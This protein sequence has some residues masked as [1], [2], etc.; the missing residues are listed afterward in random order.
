MKNDMKRKRQFDDYVEPENK[1]SNGSKR[2]NKKY[3]RNSKRTY[4]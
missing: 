1:K 2:K 3:A 4:E